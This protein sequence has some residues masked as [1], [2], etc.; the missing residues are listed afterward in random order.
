MPAYER[1]ARALLLLRRSAEALA[2]VRRGLLLDPEH[3][4]LLE[5]EEQA[6]REA[7][8]ARLDIVRAGK[9]Q[10]EWGDNHGSPGGLA[11]LCVNQSID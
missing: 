2:A 5:L 7:D 9:D 8:A 4:A 10:I 11:S 6:E 3:E 1:K